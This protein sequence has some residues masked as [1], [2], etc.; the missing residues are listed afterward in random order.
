[1]K[2]KKIQKKVF[3]DQVEYWLGVEKLDAKRGGIC[4]V[5]WPDGTVTKGMMF[6]SVPRE[7]VF[8]REGDLDIG[9]LEYPIVQYELRVRASVR[10]LTVHIPI[11]DVF[12]DRVQ[13]VQGSK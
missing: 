6:E 7:I 5:E 1:M 12:V 10:G 2:L 4:D 13:Q 3:G 9:V 8:R 11:E